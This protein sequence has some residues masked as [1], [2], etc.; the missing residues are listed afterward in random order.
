MSW[1]R[2]FRRRHE[3]AELQEEIRAYL[4][5]ETAENIARGMSAEQARRQARMK[6]GNPEG[7]REALWRQNTAPAIDDI[8]RNVKYAARTLRRTPG[9]AVIAVLVMALGIGANTALFTVVRSVLLNPLPFP[10]PDRLVA[11]YGKDDA[12]KGSVV[13]AADFYDWQSASRSFDQM[14]IW[15]WSGYNMSDNRGELPQFIQAVTCSW[16]LASTLGVTP[17]LGRSFTKADDTDEASLVVI[18]SWS[19]FKRRFNGD[20]MIIGKTIHLNLQP[21]TVVGVLP[22]SFTYPDP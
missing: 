20:P 13:A 14:A 15:R 18:L 16:N 19:F 11:L 4:E 1:R 12:G 6:L 2:F 5:E 3:D 21:Y 17:V 9:F 7:V 10:D 22:A 8:W